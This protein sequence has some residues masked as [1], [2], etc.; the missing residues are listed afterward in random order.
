MALSG[1]R[2]RIATAD[3]R[4]LPDGDGQWLLRRSFSLAVASDCYE[5]DGKPCPTR[6]RTH[7]ASLPAL[8]G[9]NSGAGPVTEFSYLFWEQQAERQS[10]C[11]LRGMCAAGCGR[12]WPV[13]I[14]RY[15]GKMWGMSIRLGLVRRLIR[16]VE[17][18]P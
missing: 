5:E 16:N 17:E 15:Q 1:Q 7:H 12:P 11:L 13:A 9:S 6:F 2:H 8:R 10:A 3:G 4:H 18:E 14:V